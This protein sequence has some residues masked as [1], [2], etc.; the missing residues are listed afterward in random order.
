MD[1]LGI[2]VKQPVPGHVKT[3]LAAALGEER[4]SALYGA[5]VADLV[6]RFRT[7]ADRRVL[8]YAPNSAEARH[9]FG[10]LACGAF[11]VWPQPETSLGARME[12]FFVDEFA[13]GRERVVVIG[14]DSPTLPAAYVEQALQLLVDHDCVLGPAADGGY[15]LVGQ[16][17]VSLPIFDDI[18]WGSHRVFE[19]TLEHIKQCGATLALLPEWY[20]VDTIEDLDRLRRE[21]AEALARCEQCI[22]PISASILE[23]L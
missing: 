2:F 20:D 23:S 11:K 19:Q 8:C 22:A 6:E 18:N 16:R 14:S 1:V 17:N 7:F 9:H 4:A 5:F 10:H 3:R 12:R 15:Y 13:A 21:L